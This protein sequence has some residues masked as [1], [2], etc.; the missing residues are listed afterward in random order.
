MQCFNTATVL[1]Q[2]G[3][4]GI[5]GFCLGIVTIHVNFT[6]Q[7][8]SSCMMICHGED[9]GLAQCSSQRTQ[10]KTLVIIVVSNEHN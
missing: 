10:L 2:V 5:S 3:Q 4:I 8:S 6:K 7:S 9:M 1:A